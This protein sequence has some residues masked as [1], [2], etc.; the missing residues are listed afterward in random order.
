MLV[1]HR[2]FLEQAPE[3]QPQT[4][5]GKRRAA[6]D[7]ENRPRRQLLNYIA[8]AAPGDEEWLTRCALH[9]HDRGIEI[10]CAS[11]DPRSLGN[12][13]DCA[14]RR[15]HGFERCPAL[16]ISGGR[17]QKPLLF[18]GSILLESFFGIPGIGSYLVDGITSA[19]FAVVRS[20]VFLSTVVYVVGLILTDISY[21]LVDPR[22]RL[23]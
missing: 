11:F 16:K 1:L 13:R 14:A 8:L 15:Q 21:S 10:E 9:Q 4:S 23:E 2:H 7:V 17:T 19:D 5:Q 22:V 20:M 12:G 6:P 18:L 3:H